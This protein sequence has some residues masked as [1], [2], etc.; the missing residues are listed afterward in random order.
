MFLTLESI[1]PFYEDTTSTRLSIIFQLVIH[2]DTS[3]HTLTH[4]LTHTHT[5]QD[6]KNYLIEKDTSRVVVQFHYSNAFH[7]GG[8][9]K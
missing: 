3:K 1:F 8:L 4:T 7:T 2:T 6:M 9:K 5:I